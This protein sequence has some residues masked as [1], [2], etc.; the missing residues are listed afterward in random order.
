M[1]GTAVRRISRDMIACNGDVIAGGIDST[2]PLSEMY[3]GY[4]D[5][6]TWL[7]MTKGHSK[8]RTFEFQC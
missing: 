6:G 4:E 1:I 8:R 3:G 2:V 5:E 7:E